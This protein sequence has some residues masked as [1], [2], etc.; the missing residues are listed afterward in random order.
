MPKETYTVAGTFQKYN[1]IHVAAV[2]DQ[3]YHCGSISKITKQSYVEV[4][5]SD[6]HLAKVCY[7]K[8][9]QYLVNDYTSSEV[10]KTTAKNQK[11]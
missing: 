10:K 2:I 4:T 8:M 7:D 11:K 6:L 3:T 9:K 5:F 1:F